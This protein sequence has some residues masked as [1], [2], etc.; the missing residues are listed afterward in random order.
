MKTFLSD[1]ATHQPDPRA[2]R[3]RKRRLHR[4]HGRSLP[5]G[6]NEKRRV[7]GMSMNGHKS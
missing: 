3:L 7:K 4:R 5:S 1:F 6:R 2:L